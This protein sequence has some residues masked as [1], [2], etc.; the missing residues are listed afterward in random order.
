[1][2]GCAVREAEERNALIELLNL[3]CR[4]AVQEERLRMEA[5]ELCVSRRKGGV[6][7]V[8]RLLIYQLCFPNFS[9][10]PFFFIIFPYKLYS[11]LN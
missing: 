10:V 11:Y 8:Q 7:G 6:G 2:A 5:G 4:L 1:M 3:R 9:Q